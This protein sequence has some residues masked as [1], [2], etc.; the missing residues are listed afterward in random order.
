M[1]AVISDIDPF[2]DVLAVTLGLPGGTDEMPELSDDGPGRRLPSPDSGVDENPRS[3]EPLVSLE[4]G[5]V[6]WREGN[7]QREAA[8][9][10]EISTA[11][12]VL[13]GNTFPWA[14]GPDWKS[15]SVT[16]EEES[17]GEE[18]VE[19]DHYSDKQLSLV[20]PAMDG[21]GHAGA[22]TPATKADSTAFIVNNLTNEHLAAN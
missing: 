6:G 3:H 8:A 12:P 18:D 2:G 9:E 16:A 15:E 17:Y 11:D 13:G 14:T 22:T 1:R 20:D 19:E 10:A 21:Y 5:N 4:K 7:A